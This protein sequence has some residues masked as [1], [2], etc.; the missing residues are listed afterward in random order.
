MFL[1]VI[2]VLEICNFENQR[3]RMGYFCAKTY[4]CIAR[5]HPAALFVDAKR[6][7]CPPKCSS[8]NDRSFHCAC[9]P[10]TLGSCLNRIPWGGKVLDDAL[11]TSLRLKN[12]PPALCS[13]EFAS[14][15]KDCRSVLKTTAG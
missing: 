3:T 9:H 15:L 7:H 4:D 1:K 2:G 11:C 13:S 12:A 8:T 10:R 6:L 5:R 14:R